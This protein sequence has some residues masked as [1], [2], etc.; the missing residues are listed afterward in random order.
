[1][2]HL[3]HARRA[4][5][6]NNNTENKKNQRRFSVFYLTGTVYIY[7][8][9]FNIGVRFT[10]YIP[11]LLYTC[12]GT[13]TVFDSSHRVHPVYIYICIVTD[14]DHIVARDEPVALI[15]KC[16]LK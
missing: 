16:E 10:H 14:D 6:R 8:Y 13:E 12:V 4:F 7:I 11:R 5:D 3:A 9:I 1:M 2:T 15:I